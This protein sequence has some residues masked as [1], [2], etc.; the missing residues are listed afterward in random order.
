MIMKWINLLTL[1]LL[2][3]LSYCQA[4][5]CANLKES[6][7][8]TRSP[9]KHQPYRIF[10]S[11][12]TMKQV[13]LITGDSSLWKIQ[14]VEDCGFTMGYLAGNDSLD[15]GQQYFLKRHVIALKIDRVTPN[16][17]LCAL[18][19]DKIGHDWYARDTLW[20]REH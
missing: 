11:G 18:Y 10:I 2:P 15:R 7:V 3:T 14:W 20:V 17:Y 9:D 6:V 19:K 12:S 8:Y 4:T 1:L 5:E 13:N 16:Y